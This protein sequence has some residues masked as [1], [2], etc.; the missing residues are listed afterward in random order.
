MPETAEIPEANDP[1]EKRI[2][3]SIAIL[4][5]LLAFLSNLGDDARTKSIIRTN[6]ATDAWGYFQA[7]SIKEHLSEVEMDTVRILYSGSKRSTLDQELLR[8]NEDRARYKKEKEEI[9]VHAETLVEE[10]KHD[11][12]INDRCDHAAL[13]LQ[14]AIVICSIA[15]LSRW[16]AIWIMGLAVGAV[17][18]VIGVT[19]MIM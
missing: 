3:I 17:G 9:K 13:M 10:A 19:A 12:E 16:H 2:A 14:I 4:A 8:L 6:E 1:F 7:K 15:I 18:A 5:V 11:G